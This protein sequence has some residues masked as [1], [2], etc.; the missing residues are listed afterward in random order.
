M[1]KQDTKK[2][3]R[4]QERYSITSGHYGVNLHV[5]GNEPDKTSQHFML[6]FC[7]LTDKKPIECLDAWPAV[8]I[9][10]AR[11]LIDEL[12]ESLDELEEPLSASVADETS[13]EDALTEGEEDERES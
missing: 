11:K 12:E 3:V 7:E 9:A 5:R 1:W 10:R 6:T 13:V 8:A 4:P 2:P